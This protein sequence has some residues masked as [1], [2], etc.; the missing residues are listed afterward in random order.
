MWLKEGSCTDVMEEA[1]VRGESQDSVF[2][3]TTYLAECRASLIC[4]E[5]LATKSNLKKRQITKDDIYPQCGKGAETSLHVFW[6]C[7]RAKEVWS[8]SK[9]V[10]PFSID[11]GWSFID[12]VWQLVN[13][14][15]ICSSLMEK[16]LSLCWEI[17]N[18]RNTV[19]NGGR[20]RA[21]KT[22]SSRFRRVERSETE[23]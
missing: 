11:N 10:F 1:W 2:P 20:H 21:G 9:T 5:A 17:W 7:Y 8:N 13:H 16:V 22:L 4:R 15:P 12:V 23:T 6:F 3:L 14:R 18:D 19:H